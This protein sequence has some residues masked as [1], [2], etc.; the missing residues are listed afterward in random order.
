MLEGLR[1]KHFLGD[2]IIFTAVKNKSALLLRLF[3]GMEKCTGDYKE[4]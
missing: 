2:E 4:K 3:K 1:E